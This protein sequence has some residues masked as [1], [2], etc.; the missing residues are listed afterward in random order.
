MREELGGETDVG[1]L[2]K[3][4]RPNMRAVYLGWDMSCGH[5]GNPSTMRTEALQD[6]LLA[7]EES[8]KRSDLHVQLRC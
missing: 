4:F 5:S 3:Q 8:M 7:F 2:T 6:H 1:L